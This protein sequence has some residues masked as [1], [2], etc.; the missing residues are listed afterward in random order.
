MGQTIVTDPQLALE[1]TQTDGFTLGKAYEGNFEAVM[2]VKGT[3]NVK[4]QVQ[5]PATGAWIN[6]RLDGKNFQ[7]NNVGDAFDVRIAPGL[8]YRF[9]TSTA[10]AE[11]YI[12]SL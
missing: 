5:N 4:L 2:T 10:G 1:T 11:V 12:C 7:L 9:N 6:L 3:S 8:N